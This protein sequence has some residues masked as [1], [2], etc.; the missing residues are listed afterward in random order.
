MEDIEFE[1]EFKAF[2][3]KEGLKAYGNYITWLRF[4]AKEGFSISR[5]LVDNDTIINHLEKNK[6]KR[7][8]YLNENNNDYSDFKA[9][10][11]K[12]RKFIATKSDLIDDIEAIIKDE[13]I[14]KTEKKRLISARIGQGNYR[15]ELINL[16]KKCAV[17]KCEMTDV[18]I[19]SHIKPWRKSTN[20]ERLDRYNGLLL[21]PNYDKLF[22]KG[23]ISFEDNGKIIISPL[24][25]EEEY[26]VLGVSPNDELFKVYDENKPYL[27]EHRR[28]V[29]HQE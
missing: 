9:A 15:E 6:S 3:K 10:L 29:F 13:I 18:L 23:L 4:I 16:W 8:I 22:D 14:P 17:S 28:I 12:Y 27:E 7:S 2:M 1:N 5:D 21:L 26:K 24:I 11:N 25:K 20:K 19:A